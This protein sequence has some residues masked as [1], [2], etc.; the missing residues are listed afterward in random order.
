[1]NDSSSSTTAPSSAAAQSLA[2]ANNSLNTT[3]LFVVVF[4]IGSFAS[5]MQI[6]LYRHHQPFFDSLS[7]YQKL[8]RVM[9]RSA[10]SGWQA[11]F[12]E[13]LT[14]HN[15][16]ALPYLLAIPVA[17]WL[18][19]SRLLAIGFQS[20]L[21][22]IFLL[23][24]DYWLREISNLGRG[25]RLMLCLSIFSLHG[26]YY[27]NGGVS[28][29][30]MDLSLM[31]S[32]AIVAICFLKTLQARQFHWALATGIALGLAC[33]C[34][35]TAPVYFA[36]GLGPIAVVS[37]WRAPD[38][39]RIIGL[40]VPMV[41]AAALVSGWFYWLNWQYLR[42]YYVDWN[43]DANKRLELWQ[44]LGHFRLC[45]RQ[46][47]ASGIILVVASAIISRLSICQRSEM[48]RQA[49]SSDKVWGPA[50]PFGIKYYWLFCHLW[51]GVAPLLLMTSLRVGL[52]LFVVWPASLMLFLTCQLALIP[53]LGQ[54]NRKAIGVLIVLLAISFVG[55]VG[56]GWIKHALPTAG[57]MK[58]HQDVIDQV[59]DDARERNRQQVRIS[60]LMTTEINAPSLLSV[61][62]F[63]RIDGVR[64]GTKI[65]LQGVA[66]SID[67]LF[68]LPARADWDNVPGNRDA[69]KIDELAALAQRRIDY[70]L[71]PTAETILALA[72]NNDNSDIVIH[73][74]LPELAQKLF[75]SNGETSGWTLITENIRGKNGYRYHLYR[76]ET[77]ARYA[78]GAT[79]PIQSPSDVFN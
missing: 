73:R 15:T 71:A 9:V 51:L 18:E 64:T 42:Y 53:R 69:D 68:F 5:W 47:G 11:A 61:L 3:W 33:L 63:D 50:E 66:V 76:N 30:R 35:A 38:K 72:N 29:F 25:W 79:L 48:E 12:D 6:L 56:R 67:A 13:I 45:F 60:T 37:L 78:G 31:V 22:L 34:R 44:A 40:A 74:Y 17:H 14:G 27:P 39:Q 52:N 26:W 46:W 20:S 36:V 57:Q 21:V 4:V 10:N 19:P 24:W 77:Y 58:L 65:E 75:P 59:L 70:L 28:D 41:V 55:A 1:M 49:L 43:T 23:L 62:T 8:D 32:Y 54:L 7:Y 16:V 2:N